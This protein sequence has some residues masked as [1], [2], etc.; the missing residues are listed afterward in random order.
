MNCLSCNIEMN[1]RI[2]PS[3]GNADC[4][5][6]GRCIICEKE[7]AG[8]CRKCNDKKHDSENERNKYNELY[9]IFQ[10][11]RAEHTRDEHYPVDLI[12]T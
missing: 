3:Y 6:H 2:T 10:N 12:E 8:L 9:D 4:V 11:L 1:D 7:I 5:T